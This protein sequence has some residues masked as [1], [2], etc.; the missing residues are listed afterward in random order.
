MVTTS[1]NPEA[2][3]RSAA[4]LQTRWN[5]SPQTTYRIMRSLPHVRIGNLIRVDIAVVEEYERRA[6]VAV[7]A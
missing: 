7:S 1:D 6:T 4:Q 2:R 3:Y 5:S